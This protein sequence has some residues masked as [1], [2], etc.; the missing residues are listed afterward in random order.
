MQ[1]TAYTLKNNRALQVQ[2]LCYVGAVCAIAGSA[3][4]VQMGNMYAAGLLAMLAAESIT[5][6]LTRHHLSLREAIRNAFI[7]GVF[8]ASATQGMSVWQAPVSWPELFSMTSPAAAVACI[9]YFVVFACV[10]AST[11]RHLSRSGS[12]CILLTP[13]LFN[14]L[15]L[16][17]SPAMLEKT[18]RLLVFGYSLPPDVLKWAGMAGVLILVNEGVAN[19]LLL[20]LAGRL[21]SDI[22]MH[23]L[24]MLSALFASATPGV[25]GLGSGAAVASLPPGMA[26]LAAIAAA[27]ASQAGLWGQ[28]FL[29]TGLIL[30]S[31]Q[32]RHPSWYWGPGHFKSGFTQ[33]AVYSGVFMGLIHSVAGVLSI[34]WARALLAAYPVAC[35]ASAGII[36]FPLCKTIMESFEGSLPFIIRLRNNYSRWDH[37]LR[38]GVVGAASAVALGEGLPAASPS[39]RFF[40]GAAAGAAAYAAVNV[41]RDAVDATILGKRQ[42]LQA[43]RIYLTEAL[44]GGLAGGA[45]CWYFDTMQA[46]A[47]AEKFKHYAALFNAAAGLKTEDYVI[48]PLFSKWGAMNLGAATGGV[49]LFYSESLSGVINWSLAAPLFSVNLVV[50]TALVSRSLAPIKNMLTPK[51]LAAMVE[52]AFRVQR[53]GLWMAPIIYTFLRMSPDPTWYNQDGAVRTGAAMIKSLTLTPGAFRAWSLQTYTQLLAYDWLRIA[54]FLD[55]MGLRVATLVNLSFVGMDVVDKKTARFLGHAIKTRVI[56]SGLRRFATWAPLLLPFYIPRGSDWSAAWAEAEAMSHPLALFPSPLIAGAFLTFSLCT[57]L[58]LLA[59]RLNEGRHPCR[60]A[61]CPD[62]KTFLLHNGLYTLTLDSSG[63]GWSR[64]F[65]AVRPG[66]EIDLTR[67]PH[68][69]LQVQGKFFYLKDLDLPPDAAER[70]WSL[71]FQPMGRAGQD[72]SVIQIDRR[73]LRIVQTFNGIRAEALVSIDSKS[74][75]ERWALRL[76]NLENR[77]RVIELTSYREFALNV[78]DACLRH[79]DYNSLHVGTW[80]VPRLHA[81]IAGNR[82]LKDAASD[83]AKRKISPEVAF[84]AVGEYPEKN[85]LLTGYE[86]SRQFFIGHGSLSLPGGLDKMPRSLSDDGLLYSFAPAAGLRLQVSLAPGAGTEVVFVD[87]YAGSI[88][89]AVPLIQ[90]NLKLPAINKK[91]L[92][93]SLEKHRTLHGFGVPTDKGAELKALAGEASDVKDPCFSFSADGTE[94]SLGGETPRPWAHVLAN[95]L[96]YGAVLT[97]EGDIYSFMGN[98]QQNGITPFFLDAVPGQ[99]LYVYNM[100]TGLVDGP[101][102]QPFRNK[103]QP[104]S[105][106]FGRGYAVY[107]KKTLDTAMEYTVFVH[108]HETAEVR[109]L[110]LKNTSSAPATYRVAPYLQIMLGEIPPDTR[111]TINAAYDE[112]LQAIFFSNPHNDFQRGSAFVATSLPVQAYE[113]VRSRFVGGPERNFAKPFMVEHGTADVQQPDDGYRIAG[114]IGT[115]TLAPGAEETIVMVVGQAKDKDTAGAI[116]RTCCDRAA[117]QEALATTK[118]WWEDILSVL[119][120]ETGTPG[121]DRM[122]NDWLPYQVYASHLWGRLG[123]NQRSGGYGYRDQLQA[124]LPLLFI[125]PEQ[126]RRQILL[127]SCQQFYAGDVLQ[128]WHQSWEGKTAQ[129]VRNRASD[130]HLWLPYAVYQYVESTGDLTIL[131]EEVTYLEGRRIPRGREGVMFTPRLSRDREP[132]Y[133]HCIRALDVA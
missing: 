81:I 65:S 126:A 117:A 2:A 83:Q 129:G 99:V 132:L 64:V 87:G 107:R 95:A 33:G 67:R 98:S 24:L 42:R 53:W 17:Q 110:K 23:G 3:M 92:R 108:A 77:A 26:G 122:V 101:T 21:L 27:M 56:P 105:I 36:I 34:P 82:S 22:R 68:D 10:L 6:G 7:A 72:Y 97:S 79:P 62:K 49:K 113:T 70:I 13:L 18:G 14:C 89:Q 44:M 133:R 54:V 88:E 45:L 71:T 85:V 96:G 40:F 114:F 4:A 128:W 115:L 63:R 91:A 100:T 124:A 16:L 74:P 76:T 86:D 69:P 29:L 58:V 130:P 43:P 90:K 106:T 55:H 39:S 111:G 75:V 93:A 125:N 66:H 11:G 51:G 25:A 60:A 20:L 116:I 131:D 84:H 103:G 118:R 112:A 31:L 57:G 80:F 5:Y 61:A 94:L 19:A 109:L 120:I 119:R 12:L 121:F 127:H 37:C 123:P 46:G 50:L 35:A 59:R 47:V 32:S 41:L 9:L 38:G 28:T 48:Y 1:Q 8:A 52:Q 78:P 30:N 73:C 15:L 102:F 104:C